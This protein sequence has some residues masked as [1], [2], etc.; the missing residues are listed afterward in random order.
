MDLMNDKVVA[1]VLF[2]LFK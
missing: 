2:D 1:Y